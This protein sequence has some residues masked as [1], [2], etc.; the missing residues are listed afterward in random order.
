M[1]TLSLING[2]VDGQTDVHGHPRHTHPNTL[3]TVKP[4]NF[5]GTFL[6]TKSHLDGFRNTHRL[7]GNDRCDI[8]SCSF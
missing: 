8:H 6:V 1:D 5:M 3:I 2:H 4:G 7:M